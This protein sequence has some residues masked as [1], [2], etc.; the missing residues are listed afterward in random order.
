MMD[1]IILAIILISI[2]FFIGWAWEEP[3]G[4]ITAVVVGIIVYWS[5]S[6]IAGIVIGIIGIAGYIHA[7]DNQK[8]RNKRE[9]QSFHQNDLYE[10]LRHCWNYNTCE[11]NWNIWIDQEDDVF[12]DDS[13]LKTKQIAINEFK[14][15]GKA[16]VRWIN[17]ELEIMMDP[18]YR[19]Y[20]ILQIREKESSIVRNLHCMFN[21][22]SE[23]SFGLS[24][25][26]LYDEVTQYRADIYDYIIHGNKQLTQEKLS[27]MIK[28]GEAICNMN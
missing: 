3:G 25:S 21:L 18:N 28:R 14:S 11:F 12:Y 19:D 16:Q 2:L 4:G 20:G 23:S 26:R 7:K 22:F 15:M 5:G 9:V 13:D 27:S 24:S 8:S 1:I 17:T 6:H 10:L